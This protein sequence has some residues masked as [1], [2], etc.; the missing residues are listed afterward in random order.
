VIELN[1]EI[2]SFSL[3]H[4]FVLEFLGQRAPVVQDLGV[5]GRSASAAACAALACLKVNG[6]KSDAY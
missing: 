2:H 5:D 6:S 4:D 3:A 1:I